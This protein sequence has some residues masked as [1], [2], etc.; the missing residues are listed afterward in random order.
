[1]MFTT[2]GG[3]LDE[4]FAEIPSLELPKHMQRLQKISRFCRYEYPP[5]N[6]TKTVHPS[7]L[8]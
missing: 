5:P 6:S 3:P 1:M 2:N 4:Y 8:S 7:V